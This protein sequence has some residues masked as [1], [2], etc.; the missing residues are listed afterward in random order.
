MHVPPRTAAAACTRERERDP[1]VAR[2]PASGGSRTQRAGVAA[3]E[4]ST[5]VRDSYVVARVATII[6]SAGQGAQSIPA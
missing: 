3:T 5:M 1:R 2:G 6:V 4:R